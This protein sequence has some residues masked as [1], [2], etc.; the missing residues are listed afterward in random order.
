MHLIITCNDVKLFILWIHGCAYKL[1]LYMIS[2][3][4]AFF[5]NMSF[6]YQWTV[7][8]KNMPLPQT[9]VKSHGCFIS[10][11]SRILSILDAD[12]WVFSSI[13]YHA[14]F[15]GNILRQF[16][17]FSRLNCFARGINTFYWHFYVFSNF[18]NVFRYSISVMKYAI[19]IPKMTLLTLKIGY[20]KM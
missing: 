8:G 12:Y 14:Q 15:P 16:F 18:W 17:T 10:V 2:C 11:R 1:L 4:C 20:R 6:I 5:A 9:R 19:K 13:Y 7:Q 3:T